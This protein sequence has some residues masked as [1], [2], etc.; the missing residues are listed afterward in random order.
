MVV[1]KI[2][3][4]CFIVLWIKKPCFTNAYSVCYDTVTEEAAV[5]KETY[6]YS[7]LWQFK[8]EKPLS[9]HKSFWF[10][11][12]LLLAG[13]IEVCPGPNIKLLCFGCLKTIRKN[14]SFGKCS[15]CHQRLHLKCIKDTLINNKETL[16]CS[17]CF[18]NNDLKMLIN[19]R[20]QSLQS[21]LNVHE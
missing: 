18:V 8:Q 15:A 7:S 5:V 4:C 1:L 2:A 20:I 6:I 17:S 10:G 11:I 3:L 19:T 9:M 16:F 14:Q 13:D 12:I 21:L